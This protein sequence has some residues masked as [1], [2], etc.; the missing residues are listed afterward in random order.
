MNKNINVKDINEVRRIGIETLVNELGIVGTINFL[1]Q[2]DM[3]HGDYTKERTDNGKS[4]M[5][6]VNEIRAIQK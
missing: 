2:F 5:D 1:R 4:V 3:G 6:V